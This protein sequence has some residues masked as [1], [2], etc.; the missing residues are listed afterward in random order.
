MPHGVP[1]L[2][3]GCGRAALHYSFLKSRILVVIFGAAGTLLFLPPLI[4]IVRPYFIY[5]EEAE[6]KVRAFSFLPLRIT[7][8]SEELATGI[9][10]RISLELRRISHYF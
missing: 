1:N 10:K 5:K 4:Q 8:E 6:F 7:V 9:Q 3:L 2:T